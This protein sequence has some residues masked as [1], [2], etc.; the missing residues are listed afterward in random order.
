[1][2]SC[3]FACINS[4]VGHLVGITSFPLCRLELK[5]RESIEHHAFPSDVQKMRPVCVFIC[6]KLQLE[7]AN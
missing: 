4:L 6:R 5:A 1:M 7:V 3:K 2:N